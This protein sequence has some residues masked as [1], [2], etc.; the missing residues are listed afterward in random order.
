MQK[1]A[2]QASGRK[3]ISESEIFFLIVIDLKFYN[4][5]TQGDIEIVA[6]V[7]ELSVGRN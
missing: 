3:W 1:I 5:G 6:R 7:I 2:P 4:T